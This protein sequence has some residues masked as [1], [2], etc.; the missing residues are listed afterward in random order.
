M[1]RCQALAAFPS[2]FQPAGTGQGLWLCV[3]RTS[4]HSKGPTSYPSR[5]PMT[6]T[7]SLC[8]NSVPWGRAVGKSPETGGLSR[9]LHSD[10][11]WLRDPLFPRVSPAAVHQIE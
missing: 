4:S 11:D 10:P 7:C 2:L 5:L 6:Q 9:Q 8:L 1:T 3:P